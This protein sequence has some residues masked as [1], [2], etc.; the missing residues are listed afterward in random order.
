[1]PAPDRSPM[2]EEFRRDN[3]SYLESRSPDFEEVKEQATR[4]EDQEVFDVDGR[5]VG[6]IMKSFVEDGKLTEC[7]IRVDGQIKREAGVKEETARIPTGWMADVGD[8]G[9]RLRVTAEQVVL[10]EEELASAHQGAESG[11]K[12]QPRKQR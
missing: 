1:M 10:S 4:L 12:G 3:I 9:V 2:A 11:A 6:R 5:R 7:E 8:D